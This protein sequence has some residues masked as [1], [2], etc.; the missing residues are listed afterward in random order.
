M[1]KSSVVF[2]LKLLSSLVFLVWFVI[3]GRD[4]FMFLFI[5]FA[6]WLGIFVLLDFVEGRLRKREKTRIKL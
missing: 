1:K 4:W 3:W 6:V 5:P 2:W